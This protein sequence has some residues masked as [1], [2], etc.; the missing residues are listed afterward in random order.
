MACAFLINCSDPEEIFPNGAE[1]QTVDSFDK[2]SGNT[3]NQKDPNGGLITLDFSD[4]KQPI[5]VNSLEEAYKYITMN[6]DTGD[7]ETKYVLQKIIRLEKELEYSKNLDLDDPQVATRYEKDFYARLGK[8]RYLRT[9]SA[10]GSLF[11]GIASGFL[12]ITIVPLNL[13]SSKRNKA[14]S[15]SRVFPLTS[16]ILCD[17]TWFRGDKYIAWRVLPGTIIIPSSF[18]N[19]TDSFF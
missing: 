3:S 11:D 18:N 5:V 8:D 1:E 2:E 10:L 17:K 7:L 13:T 9:E 4:T 6:L 15:V 12:S 14:S 16:V 19:K